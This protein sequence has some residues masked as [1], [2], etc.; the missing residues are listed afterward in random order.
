MD[1]GLSPALVAVVAASDDPD[2]A[3]MM[4]HDI[5]LGF[6]SLSPSGADSI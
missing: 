6:D 5:R 1:L 4:P 2:L 3:L